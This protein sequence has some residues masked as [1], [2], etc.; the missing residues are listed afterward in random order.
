MKP[1]CFHEEEKAGQFKGEWVCNEV[2]ERVGDGEGII[3]NVEGIG[4]WVG[5]EI[6]ER[7]GE[8]ERR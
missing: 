6:G 3:G 7:V 5:N 1:L 2:G 8:G 4:E